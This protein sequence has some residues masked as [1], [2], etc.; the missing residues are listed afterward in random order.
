[1]ELGH[2]LQ[3]KQDEDGEVDVEFLAKLMGRVGL[4]QDPMPLPE[5]ALREREQN[6]KK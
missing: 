2:I 6:A 1:L 5:W 3:A 4:R